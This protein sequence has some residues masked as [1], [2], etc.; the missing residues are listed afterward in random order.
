[1][2]SADTSLRSTPTKAHLLT[3]AGQKDDALFEQAAS[4]EQNSFEPYAN[5]AVNEVVFKA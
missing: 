3:P 4:V 2:R 5:K 1:V